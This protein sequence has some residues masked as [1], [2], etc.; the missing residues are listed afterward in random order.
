MSSLYSSPPPNLR[1]L[2]DRLVQAA[3]R[4][5]LVFGRLQQHVAVLVVA[6]LAARLTDGAGTPLLLVKGGSSLELRRGIKDSRTSKDLD[7]V[8]RIDVAEVHEL[9]ADAGE[10]GWEGFTAI[11][12]PPQEID[13]PG[14][15][16]KPRRF[17]AKLSYHGQPFASVPLEVSMVEASNAEHFDAVSSDALALVGVPVAVTV[18]CM[19]LPWQIAQKLHACTATL[20]QPKINDRAHDLV[21]LQLLEVLLADADLHQTRL[22]C[23]AVFEAR[24]EQ[25]WPPTIRALPH[26]PVIYD[27]AREGL[28]HI[29]LAETAAAAADRVQHFVAR[30]DQAAASEPNPSDNL[31]P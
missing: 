19:T 14:L 4:E 25:S 23:V 5:G 11:F 29:D 27:R 21:D 13:V 20:T 22:A 3:K 8:A 9:L 2:R 7:T 31:T 10:V 6:Q 16:V 30:I 1:S 18:P 15:R 12:T 24:A 17:I 26:W 28:D